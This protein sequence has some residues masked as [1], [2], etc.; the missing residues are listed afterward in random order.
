[1]SIV[2]LKVRLADVPEIETLSMALEAGE[3]MLR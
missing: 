3:I 2:D 1:M